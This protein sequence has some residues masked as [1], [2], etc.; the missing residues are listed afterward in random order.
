[1]SKRYR[2]WSMPINNRFQGC[3]QRLTTCRNKN[4]NEKNSQN[5]QEFHPHLH[6]LLL[7]AQKKTLLKYHAQV[8]NREKMVHNFK[9]I[10][11]R[12]RN[13]KLPL[14]EWSR[15]TSKKKIAK[16]KK[17]KPHLNHQAI[18]EQIDKRVHHPHKQPLVTIPL[19]NLKLRK[20][21]HFLAHSVHE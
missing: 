8:T 15:V 19:I 21:N 20:Q 9:D 18:S 1:M 11:N 6:H 16:S 13:K 10:I 3:L 5:L 17:S 4:K 12:L 14:M 7:F 2:P